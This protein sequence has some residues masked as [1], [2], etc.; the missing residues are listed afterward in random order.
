MVSSP[1][2]GPQVSD[3]RTLSR[4]RNGVSQSDGQTDGC[5]PQPRALPGLRCPALQGPSLACPSHPQW[6]DEGVL[7]PL[8]H[9]RSIWEQLEEVGIVHL[10]LLCAMTSG[11]AASPCLGQHCTALCWARRAPCAIRVQ[12]ALTPQAPLL[13]CSPVG[14]HDQML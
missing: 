11:S 2:K 14:T 12:E 13:C 3:G 1:W 4:Q 9:I 8:S 7:I 5:C 10:L 6:L